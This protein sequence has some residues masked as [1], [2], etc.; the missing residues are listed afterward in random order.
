MSRLYQ[1]FTELTSISKEQQC[2]KLLLLQQSDATLA[3]T[4]SS[5]LNHQSATV[6]DIF[7]KIQENLIEDDKCNLRVGRLINNKYQ[8]TKLIG[9]GG[10]SDVYQA[11]R[12]DGLIKHTV[13][14]K[15]FALADSHNTALKMLQKE[16]QILA[17]LDHHHI[18]SFIDIGYD[19]NQEPNIM[20]EY[21]DGI[22]LYEF[23]NSTPKDKAQQQVNASLFA[24]ITYAKSKGV[25]HNDLNKNNVLV[26]KQ[27]NANII[28][29]D[30]ATYQ[31]F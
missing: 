6:S 19:S 13:A 5:L 23:L 20:M 31:H 4:L 24:A 11:Q 15:Y 16:A 18:A 7:N 27:G 10:M 8:I 29:F 17:D 14:V 26:D 12:I 25:E 2:E 9:Q 30:I 28:D 1:L 3:K 21:I 22:T